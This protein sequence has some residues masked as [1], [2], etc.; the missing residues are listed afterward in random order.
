MQV[1][2]W[3]LVAAATGCCLLP[4][5]VQAIIEWPQDCCKLALQL[6]AMDGSE[7][8]CCDPNGNAEHNHGKYWAAQACLHSGT[9]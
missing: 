6:H 9:S 5:V 8:Y 3:V 7:A 2:T 4:P 1:C